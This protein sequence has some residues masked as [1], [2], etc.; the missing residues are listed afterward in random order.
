M[1][2]RAKKFNYL[3]YNYVISS[4]E[5]SSWANK[6]W[7]YEVVTRYFVTSSLV[8]IEGNYFRE[9]VRDLGYH[10]LTNSIGISIVDILC[11]GID[12]LI[13]REAFLLRIFNCQSLRMRRF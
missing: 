9:C 10:E 4:L 13:N 5:I 8:A 7:V 6:I 12:N 2:T 3:N 11:T 1:G